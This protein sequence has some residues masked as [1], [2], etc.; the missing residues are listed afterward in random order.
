MARSR[1]R[2]AAFNSADDALVQLLPKQ[3]AIFLL[4]YLADSGAHTVLEEPTY[5]D[6]DYLSEFAVFYSVSARGY[7]NRCRRCHYFSAPVTRAQLRAAAGGSGR[8]LRHL[9]DHYLG[10]IVIRPIPSAPLGRTVLRWYPDQQPATPRVVTPSRWYESHVL[11][12]TLRV[13]GLAWQQQDAGVGACATVALWSM[14]HSSAFDDHHAIPT[15]ADI[16]RF[17]HRRAS[18]GGRVF[19]ST[20]LNIFQVC[21]AIK[22]AGLAPV[23]LEGEKKHNGNAV[24]SGERFQSACAS[25]VRS[26]YPVLIICDLDSGERHAVCAVGFREAAPPPPN[27]GR[28]ELQDA[29]IKNLYVHDDNLGPSV[30]FEVVTDPS[31]FVRLKGSPP[32]RR[33]ALNLPT[34]PSATYPS[35]IPSKLVTAVHEDLRTNPDRLHRTALETAGYLCS[36]YNGLVKAGNLAGPELGLTVST[37]FM[38]M[39]QYVRAEL[40]R[41]LQGRPATLGRV[42]F[43]LWESVAPMSLHVGVVR[44]GWKS[45]PLL[46]IIYDTTDSDAN[47]WAFCNVQFNPLFGG[48]VA[49]LVK[50]GFIRVGLP[51]VAS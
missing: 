14:L 15:T 20:G 28:V 33:H 17:A 19:P 22:E 37:R 16:T 1:L 29:T 8:A 46:D 42:R 26:G 31:G 7:K 11:G 43:E 25:L 35:L 27:A 50:A 5:F 6:R 4:H 24:F 41:V 32:P 39:H 9:Q 3:Q 48:L 44:I 30:R 12:F 47:I 45:A 10:F 34:S 18:F 49:L 40:G 36:V 51:V 23:V 21:E 2:L 38:K 13:Y